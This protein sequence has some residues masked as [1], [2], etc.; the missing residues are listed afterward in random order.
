MKKWDREKKLRKL[1]MQARISNNS[2]S[3]HKWAQESKESHHSNHSFNKIKILAN[4]HLLMRAYSIL[5]R[6][7]SLNRYNRI[8]SYKPAVFLKRNP[9]C[10]QA[11]LLE[12]SSEEVLLVSSP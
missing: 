5:A 4:S 1:E 2:N 8:P 7:N 9:S 10:Q 6:A 11:K 3:N 12:T